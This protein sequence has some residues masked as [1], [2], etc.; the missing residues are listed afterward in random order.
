MLSYEISDHRTKERSAQIT[1]IQSPRIHIARVDFQGLL[2]LVKRFVH[3]PLFKEGTV[4]IIVAT[5]STC[6]CSPELW[7]VAQAK[8]HAAIAGGC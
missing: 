4:E 5:F 3:L 7:R 6:P 8:I 2:E 1:K